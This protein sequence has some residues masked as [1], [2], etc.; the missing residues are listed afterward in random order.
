MTFIDSHTH[1][2][3]I[4]FDEDRQMVVQRAL[5][6][7]VE[8]LYLPNIDVHTVDAMLSMVKKWPENCFPMLGL[9]PCS[10]GADY[11]DQLNSLYDLIDEGNYFAIGETGLDF[12]WD[13]T[14]KKEQIA[15]FEEQID[16]AIDKKLPIVIH[17]RNSIPEGIEKIKEKQKGNLTGVFHCFSGTVEEAGQIVELGFYIGIGGVATFKN[18]GL[19][20]VLK[21]IPLESLLLETDSPYLAPTPHRGK[22]NE[23]AYIP[24]IAQKIADVKEISIEEVEIVTTENALNLFGK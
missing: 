11:K 3:D 10:V 8:R 14:Y 13:T 4:K 9:H 17:T 7:G 23:S 24:L 2:F 16:W 12:Y 15:A 5:E 21:A 20:P 1:L 18:G 22:R 6:A 19:E